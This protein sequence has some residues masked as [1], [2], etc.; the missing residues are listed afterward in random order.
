MIQENSQSRTSVQ[1]I[2]HRPI[3][4]SCSMVRALLEG[5]KTQTRRI[6][7]TPPDTFEDASSILLACPYGKV[8][9]RLWV[10]ESHAIYTDAHARDK[11]YEVILY[12]ADAAAYWNMHPLDHIEAEFNPLRDTCDYEPKW[13]PSIHM[14]RWASR[15]TLEIA[16][17][18]FE[19]IQC[20][21]ATDA[22]KEGLEGRDWVG[23]AQFT[24]DKG[25]TVHGD[26]VSVFRELWISNNGKD[27]WES[28][29]RV[30]VVEFNVF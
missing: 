5:R 17:V 26:P 2:V 12:R 13:T 27:S 25:R 7:K 11:G 30:W 19:R 18:R 8:G 4:F 6:M 22:M 20:I 3:L 14:P 15:I 1:S 29:P 23:P 16:N 9:E 10:R 24:D 21:T 28:N